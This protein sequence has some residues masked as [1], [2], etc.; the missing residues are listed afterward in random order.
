MSGTRDKLKQYLKYINFTKSEKKAI[1]ILTLIILLGGCLRI[2]KI[3]HGEE[4]FFDRAKTEA[5]FSKVSAKLNSPADTSLNESVLTAD[6]NV[7][8]Q[9]EKIRLQEKIKSAENNENADKK[10]S[11]KEL[12]L[13][14]VM[15]NI[16][17]A[18][19]E[20]LMK[21]PG[22][23]ESMAEKIMLYRTSHNGF[24]KPEEIMKIKGIGK[25]KFEKIKPYITVN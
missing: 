8:S 9:E 2:I 5:A 15:I 19:K 3:S 14:G 10:K 18:S 12:A 13:K 11:K 21:L 7:L 4:K 17:T 24:K 16:N 1:L 23:G 22:V 25:K 20:E 6:T